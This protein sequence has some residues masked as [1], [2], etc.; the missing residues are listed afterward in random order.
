MFA[1]MK[2]Y[3]PPP[4]PGAQPPPLWG[5][6]DHLRALLGDR[7]TDV[8]TETGTV[9]VTLFADGAAFRDFF[10]RT[11]GPTIA[12]YRSL[13]DDPARAEELDAALAQLGDDALTDGVM[14]WEYLLLTCRRA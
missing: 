9:P 3:A 6:E 11:Y 8:V 1:T 13:A 5:D 14:K 7:V 10:K 4:P 12:V 2:P